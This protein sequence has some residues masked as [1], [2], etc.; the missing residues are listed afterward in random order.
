MQL[1]TKANGVSTDPQL[2]TE[3]REE[4]NVLTAQE[5]IKE[6]PIVDSTNQPISSEQPSAEE[7]ACANQSEDNESEKVETV[8]GVVTDC[9]K[10]NLRRNPD[11]EAEILTT[12]PALA[13]VDVD[14]EEST[15]TF[16]KVCTAAGIQG[17]CMK[18]YIAIRR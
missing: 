11:P 13:E 15:D 3:A 8:I 4:R 10:L 18:K 16:Y 1:N 2:Q 17:F 14:P 5:S 9:A 12:L 7:A 6:E